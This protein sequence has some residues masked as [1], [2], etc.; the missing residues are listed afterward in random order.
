MTSAT[1]TSEDTVAGP[2]AFAWTIVYVAD[3]TAT[4]AFYQRA[5]GFG[6]RLADPGGQ[7]AELE[8]GTTI[9]AFASAQLGASNLPGGYTAHDPARP[10]LGTELAFTTDDVPGVVRAALEAGGSLLTEA[11]TKAWGQAVAYVRDPDGVLI[12]IATP[13]A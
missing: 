2:V 1:D 4:A 8:T 13:L 11:T 7:Y 6:L 9:L 12:E 5:F 3:V 10:P